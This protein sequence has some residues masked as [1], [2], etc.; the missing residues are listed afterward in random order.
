MELTANE[1]GET[2]EI[3]IFIIHVNCYQI[4]PKLIMD[5]EDTREK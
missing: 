3:W 4:G 1:G 2:D 5:V